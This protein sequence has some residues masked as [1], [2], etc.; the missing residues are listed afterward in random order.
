VPELALVAYVDAFAA[1]TGDALQIVDR[2][3]GNAMQVAAVPGVEVAPGAHPQAPR[4]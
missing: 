3:V 2:Q 4:R 1:I